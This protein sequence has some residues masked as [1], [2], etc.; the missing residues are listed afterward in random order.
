MVIL[1][2]RV[3]RNDYFSNYLR[4]EAPSA[5]SRKQKA[6]AEAEKHEAWTNRGL[7]EGIR[8]GIK[9]GFGVGVVIQGCGP[10]FRAV[11]R[12]SGRRKDPPG[13]AFVMRN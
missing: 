5:Q 10:L 9:S 2:F 7:S 6:E 8:T 4:P 12:S 11:S 1:L 13:S 3:V